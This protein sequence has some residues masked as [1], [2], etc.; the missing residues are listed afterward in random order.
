MPLNMKK[1]IGQMAATANL[2]NLHLKKRGL[3]N[4]KKA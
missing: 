2:A 3:K 1:N 4:L